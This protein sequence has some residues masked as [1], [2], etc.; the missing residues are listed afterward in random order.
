MFFRLL[1]FRAKRKVARSF[2]RLRE[3]VASRSEVG[4]AA[5]APNQESR[6][7]PM[8]RNPGLGA[9]PSRRSISV[10]RT[11]CRTYGAPPAVCVISKLRPVSAIGTAERA[12]RERRRKSKTRSNLPHWAARPRRKQDS[13]SARGKSPAPSSPPSP[14]RNAD[15]SKWRP[16]ARPRA[17]ASASASMAA[18]AACSIFGVRLKGERRPRKVCT[19]LAPL[20]KAR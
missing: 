19:T 3:K 9:S 6:V 4:W 20:E 1:N 14:P 15:R 16:I 13:P 2:S 10:T 8:A 7:T 18:G 12:D 17:H 11:D 5:A